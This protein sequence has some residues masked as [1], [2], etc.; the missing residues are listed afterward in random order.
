MDLTLPDTANDL[1]SALRTWV[2]T[3]VQRRGYVEAFRPDHWTDFLR[4]GLLGDDSIDN[5]HRCLGFMEA[6]RGGLP[7]PVL[8]AELALRA[9]AS[10]RAAAVI[11]DGG[12]V[13]SVLP[14]K[15]GETL[16]GW[17]AVAS[18]VVD[19]RDGAVLA[20]SPLPI[21]SFT[22]PVPHGWQSIARID[23]MQDPLLTDR[24]LLS[25]ALIAGLVEGALEL[26][27]DHV[28]VR[29]QFGKAL[30]AYQAVQFPLAELADGLRLLVLDAA[31]RGDS[32]DPAWVTSAAF[33]VI[34][35][36]SVAQQATRICHQVFG[37]LGF[38][39]ETGLV[40]L[41]WGMQWLRL[42]ARISDARSLVLQGRADHRELVG[43]SMA[44]GCLV[45]EG[46]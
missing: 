34:S 5:L 19:Q 6:A 23:S 17:G 28:R 18:L 14:S 39:N 22:Y 46:A 43:T 13:T 4:W 40:P 3:R 36:D 38:C 30:G 35:A 27:V 44:P 9:D 29:E 33:A 32:D 15:P 24:W 41:T 45:L 25:S 42:A 16:V 8:E 11:A 20:T 31:N 12:I 10:G 1:R 21:A 7:G 37:A 2:D 26:A